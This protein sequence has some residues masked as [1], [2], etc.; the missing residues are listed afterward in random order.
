LG[1]CASQSHQQ[2]IAEKLE[3]LEGDWVLSTSYLGLKNAQTIANYICAEII[4][5]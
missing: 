3:N 4:L 2:W 1:K 5:Q